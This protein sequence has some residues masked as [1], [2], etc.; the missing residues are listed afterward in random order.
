VISFMPQ[1][2]YPH[3]RS[4]HGYENHTNEISMGF[5]LELC[6]FTTVSLNFTLITA[7]TKNKSGIIF[8][9]NYDNIQTFKL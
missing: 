9:F 8:N 2:F 3:G 7:Y 1:L 4:L 5:N 6:Y